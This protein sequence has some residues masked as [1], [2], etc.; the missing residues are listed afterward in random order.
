MEVLSTFCESHATEI[1]F[2]ALGRL[3]RA[4]LRV[5]DL[6]ATAARAVVRARLFAV[7]PDDLL[8][9]DD[10]TGIHDPDVALPDIDPGARQ[11]RIA[12]LVNTALLARQAPALYVIDDA[13]WMDETSE[14]MFAEF[15]S[16]IPRT[17]S[18]V[19]VTYRP[20]YHGALARAPGSQTIELALL[21]DSQLA[22]FVA[23]MIGTHSSVRTLAAQITERAAG[24]P[25]F[26]QEI[27]R[28]LVER[29][30]LQG[31]WGGYVRGSDGADISVPATV[32]ATIA[33]RIDRLSAPAKRT[34]NAAGQRCRCC[35][36]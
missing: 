19:L 15:F 27:V 13:Q 17:H 9:L 25:L 22:L 12:Q 34:L 32:S 20:E 24:N 28:D 16:V 1:P 35:S 5:T 33:A 18:M 23:E 26:A 10:L 29:V 2:H 3:M 8:L 11:R 31:D 36:G 30:A 4:V 7:E 21:S 14:A 6:D